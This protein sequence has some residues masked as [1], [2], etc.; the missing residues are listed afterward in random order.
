TEG[1]EL[2]KKKPG[3]TTE[4]AMDDEA[5]FKA[6]NEKVLKALEGTL[7]DP[8]LRGA[9]AQQITEG[10]LEKQR[11]GFKLPESQR[12]ATRKLLDQEIGKMLDDRMNPANNKDMASVVKALNKWNGKDINFSTGEPNIKDAAKKIIVDMLD[13]KESR[14]WPAAKFNAV[15]DQRL[16]KELCRCVPDPGPNAY[17]FQKPEVISNFAPVLAAMVREK[18]KGKGSA[19]LPERERGLTAAIIADRMKSMLGGPEATKAKP[20]LDAAGIKVER[21]EDLGR[22]FAAGLQN[23]RDREASIR[24]VIAK[25]KSS[26]P[27]WG[28]KHAAHVMRDQLNT[29]QPPITDKKT[30]EAVIKMVLAEMKDSIPGSESWRPELLTEGKRELATAVLRKKMWDASNSGFPIDTGLMTMGG[31]DAVAE[32]VGPLLADESFMAKDTDGKRKALHEALG[33]GVA[34]ADSAAFVLAKVINEEDL[35]TL[36]SAASFVAD[37]PIPLVPFVEVTP[38]QAANAAAELANNAYNTKVGGVSAHDVADA[39]GHG[40]NALGNAIGNG[41]NRLFGK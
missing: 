38:R 15:L 27:D 40:L 36:G 1:G 25:N 13:N 7:K 37:K 8:V 9:M 10:L 35:F 29:M 16:Q 41:Y 30:Q 34:G 32:R 23:M 6:A 21:A 33:V 28:F 14:D 2:V 31:I 39:T 19:Q 12:G 17:G 24:E 20:A 22:A 11:P 5:A 3:S 4:Y 26:D 18:V